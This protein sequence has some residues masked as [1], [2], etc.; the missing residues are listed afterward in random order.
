M[1]WFIFLGLEIRLIIAMILFQPEVGETTHLS[2]IKDVGSVTMFVM[3]LEKMRLMKMM[4]MQETYC[5]TVMSIKRRMN[6][7]RKP[8]LR[9]MMIIKS[10][11]G[12]SYSMYISCDSM[13]RPLHCKVNENC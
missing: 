3:N 2:N 1:P 8:Y 12:M 9:V 11:Q 7:M 13:K 6:V 5:Q 4:Q 10:V